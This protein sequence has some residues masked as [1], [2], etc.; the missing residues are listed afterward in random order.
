MAQP[1]TN[2]PAGWVFKQDVS[3]ADAIETR[4]LVARSQELREHITEK[5]EGWMEYM[6]EVG[7]INARVIALWV[8]SREGGLPSDADAILKL[9]E[10]DVIALMNTV[11]AQMNASREGEV[12][13][14]D[15]PL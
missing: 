7:R 15:D 8:E 9:P 13:G 3:Y 6:R 12:N 5:R 2:P 4:I 11:T 10:R 14:A 1:A